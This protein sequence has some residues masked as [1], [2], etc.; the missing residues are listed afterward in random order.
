MTPLVQNDPFNFHY[1]NSVQNQ[2]WYSVF[3]E[4][5]MSTIGY[6]RGIASKFHVVPEARAQGFGFTAANAVQSLWSTVRDFSYFF[7]V[8]GA[9]YMAFLVM[10]RKKLSPQTA[11][12]VQTV[13]PKLIITLALVTFSYAIAGFMIDLMYVVI[14]VLS[15]ILTTPGTNLTTF[16]WTQMFQALTQK[17]SVLLLLYYWLNWFVAMLGSSFFFLGYG[18]GNVISVLLLI[19][20][21]LI[22]IIVLLL[23][24]FRLWWM[25]IKTYVSILLKVAFGPIIIIGGLFGYGG[26]FGGWITGLAADL[27]VYPVTGFM[28]FMAFVLL[29]PGLPDWMPASANAFNINSAAFGSTGGVYWDPPLSIA[30]SAAE[31][32]FLFASLALISMTPKVADIIKSIIAGK[33]YGYGGAI[34]EA[35]GPVVAGWG[36]ARSGLR[37]G[38]GYGIEEVRRGGDAN[39]ALGQRFGAT[40]LGGWLSTSGTTKTVQRTVQTV[41]DRG[42]ERLKK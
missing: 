37:M 22:L 29:A 2:K 21:W 18:I 26:G 35:L 41:L 8:L 15:A 3:T 1:A 6:F 16:T 10:F 19:V 23:V 14:G 33:P 38:T 31:I 42:A 7:I 12:T 39:T 11:V 40:R 34:G 4:R 25:L 13:L 32:M 28:I 17:S 20:V 24:S 30:S 5:D 9:L 27:A 36:V